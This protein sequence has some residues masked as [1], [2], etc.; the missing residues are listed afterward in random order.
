MDE[1]QIGV[2]LVEGACD[3]YEDNGA[4]TSEVRVALEA[5]TNVHLTIN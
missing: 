3:M 5:I 1:I 2:E 4:D